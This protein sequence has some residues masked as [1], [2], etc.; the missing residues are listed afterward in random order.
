MP[1]GEQLLRAGAERPRRVGQAKAAKEAALKKQKEE[2]E[3]KKAAAAASSTQLFVALLTIVFL[4]GSTSGVSALLISQADGPVCVSCHA[5]FV[6][7]G[8]L[9]WSLP[10]LVRRRRL[11]HAQP[12]MRNAC[13]FA[14][15]VTTNCT[16]LLV[17]PP[18]L[19]W[20]HSD[21][22]IRF[23]F[24]LHLPGCPRAVPAAA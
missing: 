4:V 23:R 15:A 7:A 6:R 1:V 14:W 2:E 13:A 17:L 19:G 8:S 3:T 18:S 20:P 21:L 5:Q 10:C 22:G 11:L 9:A 16:L 24:L 12:L